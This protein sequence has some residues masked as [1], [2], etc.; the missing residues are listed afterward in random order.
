LLPEQAIDVRD[1]VPKR[2]LER[3]SL[4]EV[5]GITAGRELIYARNC[6][7][8]PNACPFEVEHADEARLQSTC[9]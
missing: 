2:D 5:E 4:Q 7:T 6:S 3:L 8:R 1:Y 9:E